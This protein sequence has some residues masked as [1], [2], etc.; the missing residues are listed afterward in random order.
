MSHTAFFVMDSG[1]LM[2]PIV[3]RLWFHFCAAIGW[4]PAALNLFLSTAMCH[5]THPTAAL[6]K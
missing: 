3:A 2:V 5:S 1:Q 6:A 4:F